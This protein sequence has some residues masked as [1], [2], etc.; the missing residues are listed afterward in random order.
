MPATKRTY[1]ITFK[2]LQAIPYNFVRGFIHAAEPSKKTLDKL[3]NSQVKIGAFV[4]G[5]MAGFI[6][7]EIIPSL[8]GN[9]LSVPANFY[10]AH[11]KN[12]FQIRN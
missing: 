5:Q 12:T 3:H 11:A 7:A 1:D 10:L 6:T 8:T 9:Y 4:N 2:P